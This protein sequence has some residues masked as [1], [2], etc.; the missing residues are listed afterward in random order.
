MALHRY[1]GPIVMPQRTHSMTSSA[2]ECC[3]VLTRVRVYVRGAVLTR[4]S[5]YVVVFLCSI[6]LDNGS[7]LTPSTEQL[8]PTLNDTYIPCTHLEYS[9]TGASTTCIPYML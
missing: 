3:P 7:P 1:K 9:F 4:V 6:H 2:A 8:V 5:M